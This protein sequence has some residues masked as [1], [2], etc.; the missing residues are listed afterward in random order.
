M[1]LSAPELQRYARHLSLPNVGV[2]GQERLRAASVLLVGAGG[3]GSPVALYLAAAG[4]GRLGLVDFD[5]V[6]VTNLQRQ[7]LHGTR[8]IGRKK[9]E[10]ARDRITDVN[11]H[12]ALDLYDTTLTSAN[13]MEIIAR[14]DV[15]VDGTDNFQTRYLTNDACVILGKPNVYGSV[16]RFEGQASVF[17]T[18]DGPCY[19]CLFREP[20]PP[21][22]V[23]N[24]AEAGV[25]GVL[26]GL[27]GMIQATET[28][29]LLLGLGEPLAGRLLLVD[30]L[31]MS[32]RTIQLRKD[33]QCPACGTRE[34]TQLI[35]YEEFCGMKANG[36][37]GGRGTGD[38]TGSDGGVREI[39]V[40]ELA[41]KLR[42]GGGDFDLIDVRE[43]YEYAIA[44][45]PGAR[46]VPMR[47]LP[48]AASSLDPSREIVLHCH[49]GAR[50]AAAAE[51][52]QGL[53]FRNVWNLAGGID[54]WS[55]EVDEKVPKY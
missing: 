27:I 29:K 28:V 26:P 33:P 18:P 11:P 20:P 15:V 47:T 13:A 35:D 39:T 55:D 1:P 45:I 4:V 2:E 53:G 23:Q 52:L 19:R 44:R 32:F 31:R 5:R 3:L 10:S 36:G 43:P 14:Y 17:A 41:A 7:V 9:I 21:G 51:Y 25:F 50:S 16:S 37:D 48:A 49:H 22:L 30:A 38:D 46:L 12:V 54:A 34:I 24:C 6:D 42:S 40:R 8:D